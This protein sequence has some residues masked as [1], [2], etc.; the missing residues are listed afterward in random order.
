MITQIEM[1]P[2][3]QSEPQVPA[4][5]LGSGSVSGKYSLIYADP[6]WTYRDNCHAGERGAGYKYD[7]MTL[8]E[9]CALPVRDLAAENCVLVMW[10]VG[11]QPREALQVCEAWG[12]TLKNMTAITWHKLTKNGKD[13]FGMGHWTRGNVENAL[14]AVRGK[15]KRA[16]AG[17]SQLVHAQVREHSR[18]P[19]EVRD[20]L[21]RLMGD[22]PR[23]ELFARQKHAGWDA[24]GNEIASDL[25]MPQNDKLTDSRP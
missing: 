2:L 18:K 1:T 11:P 8:D 23:V 17:V 12:F 15:P 13:H 22:V 25:A 3:A 24:W 7:L 5:D 20:A 21:V 4:L 6:A 16:C 10:W 9:I 14:L 19:D